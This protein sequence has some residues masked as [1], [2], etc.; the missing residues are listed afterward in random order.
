MAGKT[1]RTHGIVCW[2][3]DYKFE[4]AVSLPKDAKKKGRVYSKWDS[5]RKCEECGASTRLRLGYTKKQGVYV[6]YEDPISE[7]EDG[8]EDEPSTHRDKIGSYFSRYYERGKRL[9]PPKG[10]AR[11]WR[12]WKSSRLRRIGFYDKNDNRTKSIDDEPARIRLREESDLSSGH[13]EFKTWIQDKVEEA[14]AGEASP[15]FLSNE[16]RNEEREEALESWERVRIEIERIIDGRIIGSTNCLEGRQLSVIRKINGRLE[17][18]ARDFHLD[19]L[20]QGFH[21]SIDLEDWWKMDGRMNVIE[22]VA[23]EV[24]RCLIS[25]SSNSMAEDREIFEWRSDVN[26]GEQL[27]EFAKTNGCFVSANRAKKE[28]TEDFTDKKTGQIDRDRIKKHRERMGANLRVLHHRK[29]I[30][31]TI[32]KLMEEKVEPPREW[33]WMFVWT[34]GINF[35]PDVRTRVRRHIE[36][37]GAK[38]LEIYGDRKKR[39]EAGLEEK[40]FALSKEEEMALERFRDKGFGSSRG[41]NHE[42][43]EDCNEHNTL[44]FVYNIIIEMKREGLL[45]PAKMTPA[46]YTSYYLDG[47]ESL[48]KSRGPKPYPNNLVFTMKLE[49]IIGKSKMED[50]EEGRQNA[51][52][53]WLRGDRDRWM[54]CPPDKHEWLGGIRAGGLLRDPKISS[55]TSDYE[56]FE[57]ESRDLETGE[58]EMEGEGPKMA[59][60]VRCVPGVDIMRALNT[61]QET[62]WE[63]NL[64]LLEKVCIFEMDGGTALDDELVDKK[65][66][67]KRITPNEVF[68]PAFFDG[69]G[70]NSDT[71]R[72]MVLEWCRRII[73]HNGNVFWHSWMCDF[74]GRMV[75]RCQLLSPQKGDLSRALLRFKEWKPMGERGRFWF[76]VHVHNLMEGVEI[77]DKP[78]DGGN[79]GSRWKSGP[80]K[81]NQKF[82]IRDEWVTENLEL[83]REIGR[84]PDQYLEELGLDKRMYSKRTDFQRLAALLELDRVWAEFK[85]DGGGDW[86]SIKSGQPVYLDASC[87]GYQHVASLLGDVRLARL[88]NVIDSG[89]GP[90]DLYSE[91]AKEA[92]KEGRSKIREFLGEIGVKKSLIEECLEKIFTRGLVKQPTIVRVY[93]SNDMLKC[94][95]GR[96]GQGRPDFSMPLP[97]ILSKEE[98]TERREITAEFEEAY[99]EFVEARRLGERLPVS[100]YQQ[101]AKKKVGSGFSKGRAD[102][103]AKLLR[104]EVPVNLWAP[105][106][107]LHDAII[108]KGG[109]LAE[110]FAYPD[111]SLWQHQHGLSLLMKDVM[112]KAIGK[113]TRKAYDKLEKSLGAVTEACKPALWPGVY[114]DVMPGDEGGFRVHQ[115]YIDR[116]GSERSKRGKPTHIKSVYSGLLP[117]WYKKNHWMGHKGEKSKARIALRVCELYAKDESLAPE[118]RKFLRTAK[119]RILTKGKKFHFESH[120][121]ETIVSQAGGDSEEAREIL[122]LM[123]QREYSIPNYSKVEKERVKGMKRKVNSSMPPNFVHSLDAYHMRTSINTMRAMMSEDDHLSFWAV[124]DAFG[125]HARDIDLMRE[126]VK[127]SFFDMHRAMNLND[128]TAEMKWVGKKKIGK[129]AIGSLWKDPEK[130]GKTAGDYLIS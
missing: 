50:F 47:D 59:K 36:S 29:R 24:A 78:D 37:E 10:V 21:Q 23:N 60:T 86:E 97:R 73:E 46:Q 84:H 109:E 103:W 88:T 94:L 124:H 2:R 1:S 56:M 129:V 122:G 95:E 91:V 64:D 53:R 101:H 130:S 42:S 4:V 32:S 126:V 98:E 52:Y 44:K 116:E 14:A 40:K 71:E 80:A 16:D 7:E 28:F 65:D 45:R 68:E 89:R 79:R 113:A 118:A 9:S 69:K 72:R 33:K 51:I 41:G 128:W 12:R 117:D 31:M 57:V 66:R 114:W 100:H 96:K 102:K 92:N 18:S 107:G 13:F 67:I 106:S 17:P 77:L 115:Y 58:V 112:M 125:T 121:F 30:R 127:S 74:R 6:D 104:D 54:Y 105:G 20:D 90:Q 111:G 19:Q 35:F 49:E 48:A 38:A 81:K 55:N 83:L 26:E 22:K 87:N 5:V 99:L 76:H 3:C 15:K 62:Q 70:D 85:G 39:K 110:L 25:H 43:V 120:R 34:A 123:K 119:E 27:F 108:A 82:E 11:G 93:G 63:I 75:P 8:L 61:L